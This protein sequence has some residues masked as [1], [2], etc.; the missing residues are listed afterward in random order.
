VIEVAP[1]EERDR[2]I[3]I[4]TVFQRNQHFSTLEGDQ[5]SYVIESMEQIAAGLKGISSSIR[6]K[7]K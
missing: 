7:D 4:D 5:L 6:D 2:I 3:E 1:E